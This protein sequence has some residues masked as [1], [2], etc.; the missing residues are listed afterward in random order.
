MQPKKL[1]SIIV[2]VF[3]EQENLSLLYQEIVKAWQRLRDFYDYEIIFINDGSTDRSGEI[4]KNLIL[5]DKRVKYLEFSRNFGKEIALSAGLYHAQGRAVIMIDADLQHPPGLMPDFVKKWQQ[6]IEVVIGLRQENKDENPIRKLLSFC[7]YKGLEIMAD[8]KIVPRAT[9][10]RLI[11][12]KVVNQFNRFTEK[13][14]I[15]RGLIDWLGFKR[16]YI[17]FQASKRRGGK[18]RYDFSKLTK[19]IFSSFV[20][21]SLLP[22][23]LAGYLGVVITLFSGFLGLF[24]LVNQYL[25]IKPFSSLIF[26]GTATLAVFIL[27]LIGIVL[28]CLGL[29]ALYIANIHQEVI[30]RPI[31]VLREK[32]N[33][34]EQVLT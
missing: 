34:D 10:Y 16:D 8:T 21:H 28:V 27:F 32:K 19:L 1:I 3:N 31:Y 9:D 11:D 25:L 24:V 14:R 33:F 17:Y 26:S 18:S 20:G 15:S 2:P 5:T 12:R 7:F 23:K 6:G 29:I 30:N 22:L 13:N 4:I